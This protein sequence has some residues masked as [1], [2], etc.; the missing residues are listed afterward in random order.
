MTVGTSFKF[1]KGQIKGRDEKEE[2]LHKESLAE[3]SG[4]SLIVRT[5]KGTSITWFS[6]FHSC[7]KNY[8][9]AFKNNKQRAPRWLSWLNARL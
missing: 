9:T 7:P 4:K 6:T 1:E 8:F 2:K 5:W 3:Y